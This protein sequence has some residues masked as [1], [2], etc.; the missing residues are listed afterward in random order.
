MQ[1]RDGDTSVCTGIVDRRCDP[2][3]ICQ[4]AVENVRGLR[5]DN[6]LGEY[7]SVA[8]ESSRVLL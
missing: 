4:E 8:L 7:G 5:C 6:D 1:H 2:V 3:A